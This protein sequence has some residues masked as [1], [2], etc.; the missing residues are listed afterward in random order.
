M[1]V[2]RIR[3]V[4]LCN[5]GADA[6]LLVLGPS[7]GTSAQ[8]LWST[9]AERLAEDFHVV[10]WDL[11]GH[12]HTPAT[13][14]P[15]DMAELARGVLD[16]IDAL[17]EPHAEF[18]YAGDSIGGAVGLQLLLDAP[19]RV[20]AA[21]LL[22][23][24]AKIGTAQSW[25]ER[26]AQVRAS[27]TASLVTGSAERWFAAGFVEAHPEVASPLLE[28]LRQADAR[29]YAAACEALATFDVRERLGAIDAPVL[30]VGGAQDAVTTPDH[31][32]AIAEGVRHGRVE[33]LEGVA[34]LAPAEAP[35]A[36]AALLRA[37]FAAR[38]SAGDEGAMSLDDAYARGMVVRRE[39][40]GDAH[41]DRATASIT[42]L[43]DEFQTMIT[44]YAWNGIW[45]RPGLDRRT[46]SFITLTAMVALGHHDEFAMHVRAARTNG[47]TNDEIKEVLLQCAIYCGVPAANTAFKI[48]QGVLDDLDG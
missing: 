37:H 11:P 29:G 9:T 28:A 34:H 7:L 26:A 30:A 23:T 18:F 16:V 41:V 40:L 31:L 32:R 48:A 39:V 12:G 47:L 15:F 38:P 25:A 8:T 14:E 5:P 13:D 3:A 45:G 19:E 1:S 35:D 36:V 17:A 22:C 33:I 43:T 46:R 42:P 6:P 2:P 27:G 44:R 24:G 10:A 20:R 21:A 4:E